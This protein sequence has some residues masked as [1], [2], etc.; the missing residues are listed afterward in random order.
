[1]ATLIVKNNVLAAQLWL[2]AVRSD[3]RGFIFA[4]RKKQPISL[5][6]DSLS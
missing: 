2:N 3:G 4:L 5:V 1:M 6:F